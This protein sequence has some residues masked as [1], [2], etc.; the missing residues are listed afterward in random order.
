MNWPKIRQ[1]LQSCTTI[2]LP[3]RLSGSFLFYS[4][5]E[6]LDCSRI[7]KWKILYIRS[8]ELCKSLGHW[9]EYQNEVSLN[10]TA[11]LKL[12][13]SN[14]VSMCP[15]EQKVTSLVPVLLDVYALRTWWSWTGH[16]LAIQVPALKCPLGQAVQRNIFLHMNSLYSS[17]I[18]GIPSMCLSSLEAMKDR[19]GNK[20][21]LNQGI[22][23][24]KKAVFTRHT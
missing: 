20:P 3:V 15:C 11:A 8:S 4:L 24:Y 12:F 1:L 9:V 18:M 5:P 17:G 7:K 13:S 10:S 22:H 6:T 19:Y 2:T 23:Y 14:H 21:F 16:T